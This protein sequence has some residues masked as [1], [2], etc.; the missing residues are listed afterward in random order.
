MTA[1]DSLKRSEVISDTRPGTTKETQ[2]VAPYS[3]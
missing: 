2:D 1:K 3:G